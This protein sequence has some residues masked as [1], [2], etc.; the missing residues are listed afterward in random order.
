M[1]GIEESARFV[2]DLLNKPVE[3]PISPNPYILQQFNFIAQS[4]S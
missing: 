1:K 3:N 4:S 2:Q